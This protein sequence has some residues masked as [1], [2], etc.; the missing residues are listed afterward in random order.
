MKAIIY[1]IL[2][3]PY[4]PVILGGLLVVLPAIIPG[5]GLY[6]GTASLQFVSWRI[7]AFDQLRDGLLPTWN[8]LNGMGAPLLANYQLAF[9]YPPGWLTFIFGWIGGREGIIW[10]LG[11]L[12]S[13]H[14]I[15]AGIGMVKLLKRLGVNE[16]GQIVASL[17]FA[18]GGYWVARGSFFSMIWVGSWIPWVI[19]AISNI[20]NPLEGNVPSRRFFPTAFIICFSMQLL[21]GHAQL[22]WYTILLSASWII[23]GILVG[24]SLKNGVVSAVKFIV[25]GLIAGLL[26][27]IQLIPT[28]EYL[29]NSQRADAYAYEQAMTFSFWPWRILTVLMPN[30]FGSPGLGNYW[31]YAAYWEDAIYIGLIPFILA[32]GTFLW[33]K[34]KK[35]DI[36]GNPYRALIIFLWIIFIVG[37]CLALGKNTPIFPWLYRNIPT[38]DMFQ[39]PARFMVLCVFALSVLAGISADRWKKPTG[40]NA[41]KISQA[42]VGTVAILVGTIVAKNFLQNINPTFIQSMLL[43]G[44]FGLAMGILTLMAP[45]KD[46]SEGLKMALGGCRNYHF[47]SHHRELGFE[48][49]HSS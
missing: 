11:L 22:T 33:I 8:S 40:R 25:G 20:A 44:G 29:L 13:G 16:I 47:G 19:L 14:L 21:A 9:F 26:S 7:L 49:N 18:L 4:S 34:R 41:R 48:S 5:R 2:R 35:G 32:V 17:A 27:A 30:L 6:W 24:K 28:A 15:W 43:F 39:A 45:R 10:A 23:A 3:S 37:F 38:F 36:S 46:N 42:I 1:R 31:G 12:L